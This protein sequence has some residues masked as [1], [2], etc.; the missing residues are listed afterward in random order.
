MALRYV[1]AMVGEGEG[2]NDH[3]VKKAFIT[4]KIRGSASRQRADSFFLNQSSGIR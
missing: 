1:A 3:R 4:S 2:V